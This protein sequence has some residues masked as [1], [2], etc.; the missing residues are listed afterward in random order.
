M[1]GRPEASVSAV[2]RL[3]EVSWA[4]ID[5][6]MSRGL[7]GRPEPPCA[8]LGVDETSFLQRPDEVTI[9]SDAQA[10]IVLPRGQIGRKPSSRRG[11]PVSRRSCW[12]GS[13][14][15]AWIDGRPLSRLRWS[16]GR[17]PVEGGVGPAGG[18]F[19]VVAYPYV[20]DGP[21]GGY[22][23]NGP[24]VVVLGV[25]HRGPQGRVSAGDPGRCGV[26]WS[27]SKQR[28]GPLKGICGASLMRW[29]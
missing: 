11:L 13:S 23:R 20:E 3:M 2:A 8:H 14:G 21:S 15:S 25:P 19:R 5:R 9:G 16:L 22:R 18:A 4:A 12:S 26:D 27:R 29:S 17:G 28:P 6:I 7:A 1:D 24:A 10:G